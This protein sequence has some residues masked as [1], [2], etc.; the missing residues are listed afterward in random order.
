MTQQG[1][2]TRAIA[3][4]LYP[5]GAGAMSVNVFFAS[6]MASWLGLPVVSTLWSI[7]LGALIG[8]PVT[9]AFARHIRSLM[10]KADP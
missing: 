9:W 6:L 2:S 8:I 7:V 5:F 1:W 10:S 4:V 3:L